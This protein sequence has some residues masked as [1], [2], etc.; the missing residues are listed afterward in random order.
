M[1]S[2]GTEKEIS[3]VYWARLDAQRAKQEAAERR[4]KQLGYLKLVVVAA[5]VLVLVLG[6]QA[7][8][9]SAWW[10]IV[11]ILVL[12]FLEKTHERVLASLKKCTRVMAFYERAHMELPS[13]VR[14][15]VVPATGL[16]EQ[17][18]AI[19]NAKLAYFAPNR[20]F[21]GA[22]FRHAADPANPL[23]PFSTE[24]R[25]I[26]EADQQHFAQALEDSGMHVPKDL[27][28][29]LP[30]LLWLYQMGLILFWI[31]D[32]SLRQR[33]TAVLQKKSLA[34]LVNGLKLIR[35][36]ILRTVRKRIVELVIAVEGE[37]DDDA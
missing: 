15:A 33:S 11:P 23:S 37:G 5:T 26:R 28:L 9:A 4:H 6:L 35:L 10:L 21:L 18:T 30:K 17:L 20:A 24:T 8:I 27:A 19:I 32:R 13:H 7:Q 25:H 22:L 1:N 3:A 14:A 2:A 29:H 34:L 31:Y 36:P 12:G 16:E